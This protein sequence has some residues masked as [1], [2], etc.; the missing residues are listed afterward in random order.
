MELSIILDTIISYLD[1]YYMQ[2]C[3]QVDNSR[4]IYRSESGRKMGRRR[5]KG[6]AAKRCSVELSLE[7]CSE[8]NVFK[9]MSINFT[10]GPPTTTPPGRWQSTIY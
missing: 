3:R 10:K 7:P 2:T 9:S 4:Y 1:R 8:S 6:R 5:K